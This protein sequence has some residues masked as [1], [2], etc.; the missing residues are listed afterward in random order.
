MVGWLVNKGVEAA[1]I[2]LN[3]L[4]RNSPEGTEADQEAPQVHPVSRPRLELVASRTKV[5][6]RYLLNQHIREVMCS[7]PV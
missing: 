4:S 5:K 2:F 3:L 1:V 7:V 6:R